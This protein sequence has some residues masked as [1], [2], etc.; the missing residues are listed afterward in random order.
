VNVIHPKTGKESLMNR[1]VR[2]ITCQLSVPGWERYKQINAKTQYKFKERKLNEDEKVWL[3]ELLEQYFKKVIIKRTKV[4]VWGKVSK[5]FDPLKIDHRLVRNNRLTFLGL[6]C[7]A[8]N[9]KLFK[10]SERIV[11][12]VKK[13]ILSGEEIDKV[14]AQAAGRSL[15]IPLNEVQ[16]SLTLLNDLGF[17]SGGSS[18][19]GELIIFDEAHLYHDHTGYDKFLNFRRLEDSIEEFY[20]KLEPQVDINQPELQEKEN[21]IKNE[22]ELNKEIWKQITKEFGISKRV[23][24]KK[25]NFIKDKYIRRSIFRDV[26]DSYKLYKKGYSKPAIILGGGV[27]EEIL[28]L[29]LLEKG[30]SFQQNKFSEYVKICEENKLFRTGARRLTD[31]VRD[32]RNLVHLENEAKSKTNPSLPM[33]S[34][35]VSALFTI[36]DDL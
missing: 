12:Y 6:W 3:T 8:P 25:I 23:F 27:I 32:F 29:Y 17:F 33:A 7:I 26:E 28:R 36:I 34:N 2:M 20:N 11:N 4:N 35:V 15:G 24:G 14:N 10:Y 21:K 9:H 22:T 16:I 30:Y 31:S 1:Q 13:M 18:K 5:N 19:S